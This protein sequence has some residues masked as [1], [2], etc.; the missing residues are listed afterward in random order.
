MSTDV[1]FTHLFELEGKRRT[2]SP[3]RNDSD[4]CLA[5]G[6][7]QKCVDVLEKQAQSSARPSSSR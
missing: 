1:F 7:A 4:L 5:H 2:F 6:C 3:L